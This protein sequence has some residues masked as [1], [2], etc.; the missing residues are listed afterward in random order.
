MKYIKKH[1]FNFVIVAMLG[2]FIF[3]AGPVGALAQDYPVK[4]IN[5]YVGF[6]PGGAGSNSIHIFAE[7]AKKY[8]SNP[9]PI[10]IINKPGASTAIAADFVL[11][12]PADGYSLFLF[13]TDICGKLAKDGDKLSFKMEDFIPI[14]TYGVSP[15]MLVVSKEKSPFKTLDDFLWL[16]QETSRTTFLRFYGCRFDRPF[17]R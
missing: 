2:L 7:G 4:P 8:L 11:K 12:Q 16:C 6:S 17:D 13:P 10:L 14:G 3:L 1:I 15:I 5:I 9:Q